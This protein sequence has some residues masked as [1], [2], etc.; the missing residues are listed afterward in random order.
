M[1]RLQAKVALREDKDA[2]VA[3]QASHA[4]SR[5]TGRAH[6]GHRFMAR[7]SARLNGIDRI[8]LDI[9]AV[10]FSRARISKAQ[11][12][13]EVG[14]S[15]SRCYERMRHLEQAEIVRGYHA[16]VDFVR[17]TS[18]M[19]FVVEIKLLNY[20]SAHSRLFEKAVLQTAEIISC[21][22]VLGQID[23]VIVVVAASVEK[24]QT[25]IDKLRVSTDNEFDFVTFAVSKTIKS[26]GESD[27]Q[28]IVGALTQDNSTSS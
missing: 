17:L 2:R 14:L 3:F 12:G 20:T 10:L 28:K 5:H 11:M 25:V 4:H 15:A 21:Q 13:A 24:Y 1:I 19:Q 26:P 22:S 6:R 9:L 23:Y 16:D 7:K 8:D 27:L 18:C